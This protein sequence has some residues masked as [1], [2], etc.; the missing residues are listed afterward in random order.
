MD[1]PDPLEAAW[2]LR[3]LVVAHVHDPSDLVALALSLPCAL[4]APCLLELRDLRVPALLDGLV[5]ACARGDARTA[6]ALLCGRPFDVRLHAARDTS[7]G[8]SMLVRWACMHSARASG[9]AELPALLAGPPLRIAGDE[10]AWFGDAGAFTSACWFGLP[11]AVSLLPG[12]V[13]ADEAERQRLLC[14]G[15]LNAFRRGHAEVVTALLRSWGWREDRMSADLVAELLKQNSFSHLQRLSRPDDVPR[16]PSLFFYRMCMEVACRQRYRDSAECLAVLA[17]PPFLLGQPDARCV[18]ALD[19]ACASGHARAVDVLA[20]RPYDL[21]YDDARAERQ[22]VLASAC[23]S[24]SAATVRR[25]ALP[26]FS[27]GRAEAAAGNGAALE[28]A[29]VGGHRDVVRLL[30]QAPYSM[31]RQDLVDNPDSVF[32]HTCANGHAGVLEELAGP[33]FSLRQ[34]DAQ[35]STFLTALS[36]AC[37]NGHAEV[38]RVLARP[39]YSLGEEDARVDGNEPL[40]SACR[41]GHCEIVRM[42]ARPPFSMGTAE[43]QF[44]ECEALRAAC[45]EGH[46]DVI[47]I[48]GEPPYSLGAAEARARNNDALFYACKNRRG[49]VVRALGEPPYSLGRADAVAAGRRVTRTQEYLCFRAVADVLRSP[50]Y[51]FS[52][53]SPSQLQNPSTCVLQ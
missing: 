32:V 33:P 26:P 38:V 23:A 13:V 50:P 52:F 45:C 43:A 16:V 4:A 7:S 5:R 6:L 22:S 20:E 39:P 49:D 25:L 53:S 10:S 40:I 37:R 36:H 14:S 24:G 31:T 2:C 21:G 18:C 17:R 8:I 44:M 1:E 42:L 29:C 12:L 51:N 3:T 27:L 34:Q 30:G 41:N 9:S 19:L 15:V 35:S 46:L 48:L 11:S 28:A 47:R